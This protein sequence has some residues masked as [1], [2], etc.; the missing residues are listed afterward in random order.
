MQKEE[1]NTNI[2]DAKEVETRQEAQV[3]K[4]SCTNMEEDL[5]VTNNVN[6]SSSNTSI[7]KLT[8]YFLSSPNIEVGKRKSIEP[9]QKY[10]MYLKCV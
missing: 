1:C 4:E 8:N 5:K 7:N 3:V 6:G 10:R 2:G 9:M